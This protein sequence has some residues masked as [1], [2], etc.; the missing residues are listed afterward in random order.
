MSYDISEGAAY[1][2]LYTVLAGFSLLAILAAGYC[3]TSPMLHKLGIIM[4]PTAGSE[5]E[6]KKV[7]GSADFFLAARNSAG[8]R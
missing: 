5:E 7:A 1:A 8:A 4:C 6:V 2:V 3:G